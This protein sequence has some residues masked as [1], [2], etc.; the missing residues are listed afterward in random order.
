[1]KHQADA[2]NKSTD[3]QDSAQ[4]APDR[5]QPK[6]QQRK[7]LRQD[8]ATGIGKALREELQLAGFTKALFFLPLPNWY[9]RTWVETMINSPFVPELEH[10]ARVVHGLNLK[11]LKDG[12]QLAIRLSFQCQRSGRS[13]VVDLS[14]PSFD[15]CR[16][17]ALVW[18]SEKVGPECTKNGQH[19][20]RL[21]G[22]VRGASKLND[23]R[24]LLLNAG[25]T[26]TIFIIAIEDGTVVKTYADIESAGKPEA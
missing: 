18:L 7:A 2:R 15:V 16:Q 6:D 14:T 11:V 10:L 25:V 24:K 20:E 4:P 3:E 22:K 19:R 13:K 17:T 12:R 1:M 26:V 8:E 23:I 21:V 5:P 9:D